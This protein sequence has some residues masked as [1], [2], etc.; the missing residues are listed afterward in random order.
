[1]DVERKNITQPTDWWKAFE[2]AARDE[3]LSL[4]AWIGKA[5]LK[6]LP[7]EV[8]RSLSERKP[9]GRPKQ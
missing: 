8:V 3:G 4:S 2:K 6:Q 9:S 5:A 7:R 1:M